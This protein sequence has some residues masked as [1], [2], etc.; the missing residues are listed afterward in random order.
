[1]VWLN[2]PEHEKIYLFNYLLSSNL[3][4]GVFEESEPAEGVSCVLQA[5]ADPKLVLQR[6]PY[7]VH[8]SDIHQTMSYVEEQG[9]IRVACERKA[10]TQY[11]QP[12]E[13]GQLH[14]L[15]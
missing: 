9:L 14:L 15:L 2:L 8:E 7:E 3:T 5:A 12:G 13:N 11:Q 6:T 1:M 4:G 10:V